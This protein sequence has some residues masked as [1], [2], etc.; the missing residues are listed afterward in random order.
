MGF[1][2]GL[3]MVLIGGSHLASPG[4]LINSLHDELIQQGAKVYTLGVCG[5]Q[6]S[7]W[8]KTTP[9]TCGAAERKGAE[10]PKFYLGKSGNTRPITQIMAENQPDWV[11][12][13]MGDNFAGYKTGLEKQWAFQEVSQLIGAITKNPRT[14]CAWVGPTWGRDGG[15]F[16]KTDAGVSTVSQFLSVNTKPCVYINS[17]DFSKPGQWPVEA[18]GQ[19]LKPDGY[20]LWGRAISRSLQQV[21]K[22]P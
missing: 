8:T 2:T 11:V 5:S 16:G 6:P 12:V 4:Y 15:P 19:H 17:L 10:R 18:D 9:S 3:S 22:A 1:A 14:H 21:V 7:D 13:V 20:R